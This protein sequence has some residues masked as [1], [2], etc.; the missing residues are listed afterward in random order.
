MAFAW[1]LTKSRGFPFSDFLIRISHIDLTA[2]G[3]CQENFLLII[4]SPEIVLSI[5]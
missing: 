1:F 4:G 2:F 3:F 5:P